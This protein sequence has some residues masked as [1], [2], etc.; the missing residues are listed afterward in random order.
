M[1]IL[2]LKLISYS[3]HENN[4]EIIHGCRLRCLHGIS[5]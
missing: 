1:M 4:I 5:P 2:Q 3:T